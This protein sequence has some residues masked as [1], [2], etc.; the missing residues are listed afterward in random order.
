MFYITLAQTMF[1]DFMYLL[2]SCIFFFSSSLQ[3]IRMSEIKDDEW[4]KKDYTPVSYIEYEDVNLDDINAVFDETEV[5]VN[6]R[7]SFYFCAYLPI[8]LYT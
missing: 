4:F 3:R 6:F 8:V 5:S 2:L 1:N 7:T